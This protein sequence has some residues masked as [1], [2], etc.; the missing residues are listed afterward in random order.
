M[1]KTISDLQ[2]FVR[3]GGGLNIDASSMTTSNIQS[4]ARLANGSGVKLILR[5]ADTKSV[6]DLQSFARLAP[7]NVIFE[8]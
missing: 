7:G 2:S 3:L 1:P 4:L 5:N 6:S 8:L